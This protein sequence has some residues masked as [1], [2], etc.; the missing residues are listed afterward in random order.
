MAPFNVTA[1]YPDMQAARRGVEA[2]EEQGVDADDISLLGR[3]AADA[4]APYDTAEHDAA[5][6]EMTKKTALGGISAGGGLGA[7]GG[8]LAGIAVFGIPGAGPVVGGG[9][10]ALVA[11]GAVAGA[12]TGLTVA[13]LAKIKQSQEWEATFTHVTEGA[14][15]VAAHTD[16]EASYHKAASALEGSG[17]TELRRF[18]AEGQ[19]L[20]A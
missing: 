15:I 18:D 11:G 12:G 1:V 5:V 16:E 4:E 2:L 19:P 3:P 13:S 9:I 10:L 8:F 20:P 17:A 6:L 7:L 14:V